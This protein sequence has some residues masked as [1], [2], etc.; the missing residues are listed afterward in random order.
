M[1]GPSQQ[2][3]ATDHALQCPVCR[4]LTGRVQPVTRRVVRCPRCGQM[5]AICEAN[6]TNRHKPNC[7]GHVA[8]P[9]SDIG[10]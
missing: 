6:I 1:I 2:F 8:E 4:C 5:F 10:G 7:V 3:V 9:A